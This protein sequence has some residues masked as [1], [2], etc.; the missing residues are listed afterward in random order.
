MTRKEFDQI[1]YETLVAMGDQDDAMQVKIDPEWD[2]DY[3]EMKHLTPDQ[4]RMLCEAGI[5]IQQQ[6]GRA[7]LN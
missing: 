2:K 7:A 3:E 1:I 4:L 5:N 6:L